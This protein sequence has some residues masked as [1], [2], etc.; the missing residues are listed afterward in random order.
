MKNGTKITLN[1]SSS[2]IGS[3]NGE[4]N[5]LHKLLVTNTQV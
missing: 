3:S 1:L 4:T 5:F 2:L